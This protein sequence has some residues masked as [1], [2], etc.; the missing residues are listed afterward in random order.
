MVVLLTLSLRG[1]LQEKVMLSWWN[2]GALMR[3]QE[4]PRHLKKTQEILML[5]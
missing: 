1:T 4:A 3:G 2:A 5:P